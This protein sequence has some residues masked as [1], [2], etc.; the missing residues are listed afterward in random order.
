MLYLVVNELKNFMNIQ[1]Q[2]MKDNTSNDASLNFMS[3]N[4]PKIIIKL[5]K[6][7]LLLE[8]IGLS[9]IIDSHLCHLF[10]CCLLHS[11]Y[12]SSRYELFVLLYRLLLN[13]FLFNWN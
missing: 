4:H 10:N 8:M 5:I 3:M 6:I 1:Q 11:P 12:V 7:L 9:F 2:S 13:I